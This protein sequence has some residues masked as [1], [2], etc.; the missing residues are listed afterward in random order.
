MKKRCMQCQAVLMENV[1]QCPLCYRDI[2]DSEPLFSLEDVP[3][4]FVKRKNDKIFGP[5]PKAKVVSLVSTG[6]LEATEAVSDDRETWVPVSGIQDFAALLKAGAPVAELR[7]Q[8]DLPAH[9]TPGA[10]S[11]ELPGLKP[12][13]VAAD[14]PGL[15]Q[16]PVAAD[17]PGLKPP[18]VA[19]DLPV[20]K[21]AG[22]IPS[23]QIPTLLV[24][25]KN[26]GTPTPVT[27][28]PGMKT[29][30]PGVRTDLPGMRTDLPGVRTDLPGARTDLPGMRT[31]LPGARTDLPGARTDLPE[32]KIELP[33]PASSFPGM[34]EGKPS[35]LENEDLEREKN[36]DFSLPPLGGGVVPEM[37]LEL[38]PGKAHPLELGDPDAGKPGEP[39]VKIPPSLFD[40]S[41]GVDLSALGGG[42][43]PGPGNKSGLDLDHPPSSLP[44]SGMSLS[45][46]D[47]ELAPQGAVAGRPVDGTSRSKKT[48][49]ESRDRKSVV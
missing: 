7:E 21:P 43:V 45:L 44:P 6:K 3:T 17:L 48:G 20:L 23:S 46:S 1:T 5:F 4:L 16:A 37:K 42:S 41:D 18:P 34:R 32:L 25:G 33:A 15:K 11:V 35:N 22:A 49:K 19:V 24:P 39:G 12:P 8:P 28:L 9:K 26:A 40:S 27:D 31:D 2:V 10:G 47:E 13:P 36:R 14:L 29:D 38:N 30:L